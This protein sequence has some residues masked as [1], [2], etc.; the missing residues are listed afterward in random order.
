MKATV[1]IWFLVGMYQYAALNLGYEIEIAGRFLKGRMGPPSLAPEA[2]YYGSLSMLQLMY[3]LSEQS[4][5]SRIFIGLAVASVVMSG[6]LLAMILLVFVL[7][8]LPRKWLVG[9]AVAVPLLILVDFH[10]TSAGV[11]SRLASITAEGYSVAAFFLDASL[12]LRV[13][14]M[15]FTMVAN[16]MPS[17]LLLGPVDF[18]TQYNAFAA[19]T[20]LL[21]QTGTG[22]ILPAVGEMIYN[23]GIPGVLL[24]AGVMKRGL[25]NSTTR[26]AKIEKLAFVIACMMNPITIANVFLIVYVQ[27]RTGPE[28]TRQVGARMRNTP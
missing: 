19:S 3:L 24:L 22:Y 11:T 1:V 6:S 26:G 7:W 16:L 14:H 21:I 5:K 13:G 28:V 10:L 2:S 27:A 4:R 12:N 20:G 9:V 25:E 18:M 17:L 15:Y 8:R 23:A